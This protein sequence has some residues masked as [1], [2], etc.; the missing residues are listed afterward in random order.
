MAS[1]FHCLRWGL[2]ASISPREL[3]ARASLNAGEGHWLGISVS[4]SGFSSSLGH[5]FSSSKVLGFTCNESLSLRFSLIQDQHLF[6]PDRG[7]GRI[8]MSCGWKSSDAVASGADHWEPNPALMSCIASLPFLTMT[9]PSFRPVAIPTSETWLDS[10]CL[11]LLT[12]ISIWGG[13][14]S[15]CT[16]LM[17]K[18][19]SL[20]R[21]LA[22]SRCPCFLLHKTNPFKVGVQGYY[23][24][25]LSAQC[26]LP[27]LILLFLLGIVSLKIRWEDLRITVK[28]S[29][30]E[31]LEPC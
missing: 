5:S 4:Q 8:R 25:M 31:D 24:F 20:A 23:I 30:V 7:P 14:P 12:W 18:T 3:S 16:F 22:E 10:Q 9:P 11:W 2:R 6:S 1:L 26:C 27:V 15:L 29:R 19:Q 17:T 28:S 13:R 21:T